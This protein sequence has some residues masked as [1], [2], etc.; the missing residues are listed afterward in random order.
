MFSVMLVDDEKWIVQSILAKGNWQKHGL[1]VVAVAYN[2]LEALAKIESERPDVVLTDIRMPGM[3]G[4]EV[5]GQTKEKGLHAEFVIISGYS[6]FDYVK[7]ALQLG[8][9]DY[10]LKSVDEDE[11]NEVL[12]RLVDK[13]HSVKHLAGLHLAA[14]L[15][16][17]LPE[18]HA[19]IERI[20]QQNSLSPIANR[21]SVLCV[22]GDYEIPR[23]T[24]LPCIVIKIGNRIHAMFINVEDQPSWLLIL[25]GGECVFDGIGIGKPVE[26]IQ[27]LELAI[28]TATF[29]AGRF[30]LT[31]R[32]GEAHFYRRGKDS[33]NELSTQLYASILSRK[34]KETVCIFEQLRE[35]LKE[36]GAELYQAL[37]LYV[38][39]LSATQQDVDVSGDVSTQLPCTLLTTFTDV[40]RMFD[41]LEHL[42]IA[43]MMEPTEPASGGTHHEI[44]KQIVT[45]I[46]TD[47]TKDLSLQTVARLFNL[48][49]NYVSQLFQKK[50]QT[51]FT[52]LL[53]SVRLEQA[54]K[55]LRVTNLSINEIAEQIGYSDYFYFAKVF[56]KKFGVTPTQ[57]RNEK[58]TIM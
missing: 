51:T 8:A 54:C 7:K 23:P 32:K 53:T 20:L 42:T 49:P 29:A 24:G 33:N 4:L 14:L 47:F 19:N 56:K 58:R 36:E 13:L 30:F 28:Q 41:Y 50:L 18:N 34:L 21:L 6:D 22:I 44:L 26:E 12:A 11:L 2:G 48:H 1:N 38:L 25:A 10:I 43:A 45:Y 31:G 39:V 15:Q 46:E 37:Q 16:N 9:I 5:M 3:S 57:Y 27:Q 40:D 55:L 17:G 35:L 52:K